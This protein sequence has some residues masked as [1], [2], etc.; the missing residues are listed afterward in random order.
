MSQHLTCRKYLTSLTKTVNKVVEEINNIFY[1]G[2]CHNLAICR[3]AAQKAILLHFLLTWRLKDY[4]V[5]SVQWFS[6]PDS[7]RTCSRFYLMSLLTKS[8]TSETQWWYFS[9]KLG[10]VFEQRLVNWTNLILNGI[11]NRMVF[12]L[13][14]KAIL[15]KGSRVMHFYVNITVQ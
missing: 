5:C 2:F 15:I 12:N 7:K 6:N 14:R 1:F 11:L 13:V 3:I 10:I 4:I 9:D 8:L